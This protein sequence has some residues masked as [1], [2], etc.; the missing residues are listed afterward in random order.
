MDCGAQAPSPAADKYFSAAEGGC[1]PTFYFW[2]T[3]ILFG[4]RAIL[5]RTQLREH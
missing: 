2:Q 4:C 3:E 5:V 1:V